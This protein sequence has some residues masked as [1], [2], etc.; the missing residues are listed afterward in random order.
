MPPLLPV[1]IGPYKY[2]NTIVSIFFRR[3]YQVVMSVL[4]YI[5]ILLYAE[6]RDFASAV[7]NEAGFTVSVDILYTE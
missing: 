5:L 7:L 4:P 2:L 6:T 3:Y 1:K